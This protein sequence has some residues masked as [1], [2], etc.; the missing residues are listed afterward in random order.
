MPGGFGGERGSN[1]RLQSSISQSIYRK[2]PGNGDLDR[3]AEIR[4]SSGLWIRLEV[5]RD[6]PGK[7]RLVEPPC[8][9]RQ[10]DLDGIHRIGAQSLAV[11]AQEQGDAQKRSPLVAVDEGVL[12]GD[13]EAVSGGKLRQVVRAVVKESIDRPRQRG[14]EWPLVAQT[15]GPAE[16]GEALP[17]KQR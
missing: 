1:T 2:R 7:S 16:R 13:A 4:E 8:R 3:A 10:H 17:M 12:P 5:C 6:P 15:R 11:E 14:V 9:H